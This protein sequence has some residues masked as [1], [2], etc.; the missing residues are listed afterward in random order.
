M[1]H[2]LQIATCCVLLIPFTGAMAEGGYYGS[3]PYLSP[4]APQAHAWNPSYPYDRYQFQGDRMRTGNPVYTDTT[5]YPPQTRKYIEGFNPYT[6]MHPGNLQFRPWNDQGTFR[7]GNDRGFQGPGS[8]DYDFPPPMPSFG[9]SQGYPYPT[10]PQRGFDNAPGYGYR[11]PGP[12]YGYPGYGYP[13]TSTNYQ[14]YYNY[15]SSGFFPPTPDVMPYGEWQEPMPPAYGGQATPEW[16]Y[17]YPDFGMPA[18]DFQRGGAFDNSFRGPVDGIAAP[19]RQRTTAPPLDRFD[20]YEL[21][22]PTMLDDRAPAPPSA[23]QAVA[24]AS[25]AEETV[26]PTAPQQQP[27][28]AAPPQPDE[29]KPESAPEAPPPM[30]EETQSDPEAKESPNSGESLEAEPKET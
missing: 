1:K 26:T 5:Y 9:A 4:G 12:G 27:P 15:P 29:A 18:P 8:S 21:P 14:P 6:R 20:L 7:S 10:S 19:S 23:T 28:P 11:Q 2:P 25:L 17:P 24:P 3:N 16:G 22:L 30:T 13:S